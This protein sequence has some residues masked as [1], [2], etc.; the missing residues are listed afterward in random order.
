MTPVAF[1]ICLFSDIVKRDLSSA[2]QQLLCDLTAT[3]HHQATNK[4]E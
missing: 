4:Q 1:D 2:K 3:D